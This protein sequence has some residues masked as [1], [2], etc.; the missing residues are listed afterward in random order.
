MRPYIYTYKYVLK[1]VLR[2]QKPFLDL[3]LWLLTGGWKDTK[4]HSYVR[5]L[6]RVSIGGRAGRDRHHRRTALRLGWKSSLAT[7]ACAFSALTFRPADHTKNAVLC[8]DDRITP[9]TFEWAS[10][11]SYSRRRGVIYRDV[12]VPAEGSLYYIRIFVLETRAWK[13][14]R[15]FL[16]GFFLLRSESYSNFN[17]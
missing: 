14:N 7:D 2:V 11:Q 1:H 13:G 12:A 17:F 4:S 3:T 16:I 9:Q 8:T 10:S 6:T 5:G 15:F